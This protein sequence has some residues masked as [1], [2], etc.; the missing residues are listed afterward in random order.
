MRLGFFVF[1]MIV[2]S[3]S[4]GA[5]PIE[6]EEKLKEEYDLYHGIIIASPG[7]LGTAVMRQTGTFGSAPSA[8]CN[9]GKA[10]P[11]EA[12]N[13]YYYNQPIE[14]LRLEL[15]ARA[16]MQPRNGNS[17]A[18]GWVV[19]EK[20]GEII[21]VFEPVGEMEEGRWKGNLLSS[22]STEKSTISVWNGLNGVGGRL[23]F[24]LMTGQ[25]FYF[26]RPNTDVPSFFL[27]DCR[28]I[29]KQGLPIYQ[30]KFKG[31]D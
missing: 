18:M 1:L 7:S 6:L 8:I 20:N 5:V 30:I 17:T 28:K 26:D 21:K 13:D 31:V 27:Y 12:G 15:R 4:V 29:Q 25:G 14:G 16:I 22:W 19:F 11:S 23:A 24:D 2:L 10:I 9:V 3:N